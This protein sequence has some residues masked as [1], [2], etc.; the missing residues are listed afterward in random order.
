MLQT[1][2]TA[3][4]ASTFGRIFGIARKSATTTEAH[5]KANA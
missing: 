5:D 3:R 4:A 1:K 2:T